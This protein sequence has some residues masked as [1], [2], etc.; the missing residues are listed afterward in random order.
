[1][2]NS[3]K[4]NLHWIFY[5]GSIIC[6]VFYISYNVSQ[7]QLNADPLYFSIILLIIVLSLWI[8]IAIV[9]NRFSIK[10]CLYVICFTGIVVALTILM[11]YGIT[12]EIG[13]TSGRLA[14]TPYPQILVYVFLM[15][16][17]F[18]LPV[19]FYQIKKVSKPD[20]DFMTHDNKAFSQEPKVASDNLNDCFN[21]STEEEVEENH[22]DGDWEEATS[23]DLESG[24]YELI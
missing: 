18:S 15:L 21:Q 19:V 23:E 7:I 3:I 6:Y 9:L 4:N 24:E 11:L 20:V 17:S 22:I 1:M 5:F 8:A 12:P 14:F 2:L 13:A 10:H 16:F